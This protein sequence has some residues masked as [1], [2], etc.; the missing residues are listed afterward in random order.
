MSLSDREIETLNTYAEFTLDEV[1]LLGERPELSSRAIS[2]GWA[3]M[4]SSSPAHIEATTDFSSPTGRALGSRLLSVAV[5]ESHRDAVLEQL[6]HTR[7]PL[8]S[9]RIILS[10]RIDHGREILTTVIR[11]E[12][13]GADGADLALLTAPGYL[14]E[15]LET[16]TRLGR[17]RIEAER[18]ELD[19]LPILWAAGTGGVLLHESA[20][21]PAGVSPAVRWPEWLRVF[22]DPA[23]PV[24]DRSAGETSPTRR[25]DLLSSEQPSSRRRASFREHPMPR[26]STLVASAVGPVPFHLPSRYVEVELAEGGRWDPLTDAVSIRVLSASVIEDNVRRRLAP[27]E[28]VSGRADVAQSLTGARGEPARYPGVLC[29]EHGQRIPV[30][31][32][33]LDLLTEGI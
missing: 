27:F 11:L 25:S 21:H 22:D 13:A 14:A 6:F 32:Y 31:T 5:L 18:S 24:F 4:S 2:R 29:S 10:H 3:L 7:S 12:L 17:R 1:W 9:A 16:L 20:G 30:G 8:L 23:V 28:I 15:D 33:C 19:P 26:M